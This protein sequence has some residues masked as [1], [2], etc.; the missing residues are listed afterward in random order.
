MSVEFT[1][2]EASDHLLNLSP[3]ELKTMLHHILS[4]KEFVIQTGNLFSLI[5]MMYDT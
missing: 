2:E 4:G 1:G 5:L 3:Y